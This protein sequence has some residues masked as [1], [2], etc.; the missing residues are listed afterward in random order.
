LRG[1]CNWIIINGGLCYLTQQK[2][3]CLCGPCSSNE[4]DDCES[5]KW[6]DKW[7]HVSLPIRQCITM[8]FAQLEEDQS[9]I[10]SNYD[11]VLDLILPGSV[12]P[13]IKF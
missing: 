6:V 2:L 8:E 11:H 4:W 5:T 10:S 13:S 12:K 7:D 1:N 3:S 9:K